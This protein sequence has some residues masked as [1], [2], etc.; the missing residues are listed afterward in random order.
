MTTPNLNATG[1]WW[2]GALVRF[3]FQLEYQKGWDNT[4]ANV[5]SQITTHLNQEAVRSILDGVTLGVIHRAEGYHPA[6]VEGDCGMEKEVCVA[7]GWLLVEMHV[8]AWADA[9]REG[10]VLSTVLNWLEAQKK[11]DLQ[12]LLGE[13]ASSE[14]GPLVLRN[15]QNFTIHQKVLYLHSMPKGE[16]ED[17]LLFMV[18]RA[19]WVVALN[20]CH[21]DAGHQGC[22]HT[23]CLLQEHFWWPGMASQM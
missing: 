15:C 16:N 18:P 7:A 17:L 10:P 23:R 22:D 5:L 11:T 2:D 9:Q 12:T 19:H 13:H 20:G 8:T 14:E 6:V 1:H 4:V 21:W 3:N